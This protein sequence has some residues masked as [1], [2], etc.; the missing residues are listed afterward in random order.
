MLRPVPDKTQQSQETDIHSRGGFEPA[1]PTSERPQT[2]ALDR[3]ATGIGNTLKQ[4]IQFSFRL[5]LTMWGGTCARLH[6]VY[7]STGALP[8]S[9]HKSSKS[10][11][12]RPAAHAAVLR[13]SASQGTFGERCVYLFLQLG[14]P[15]VDIPTLSILSSC[16]AKPRPPP[17]ATPQKYVLP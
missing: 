9:G 2:Y 14:L 5:A 8:P 4:Y 11:D 3:A 16:L 7:W 10:S 15:K 1:I 6:R 13:P 12:R 17:P